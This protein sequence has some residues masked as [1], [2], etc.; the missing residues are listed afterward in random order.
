MAFTGSQKAYCMLLRKMNLLWQFKGNFIQ[1]MNCNFQRIKKFTHN[2]RNLLAWWKT[3]WLFKPFRRKGY[4]CTRFIC[5]KFKRINL[6][7]EYRITYSVKSVWHIVWKN[8]QMKPYQLQLMQQL[9]SNSM[10]IFFF[11]F[12]LRLHQW[13]SVCAP[14]AS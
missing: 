10:Q 12:F 11:F 5:T 7:C 3:N 13:F 8:L 14:Y 1:N 2:F 4:S 6:S 9:C